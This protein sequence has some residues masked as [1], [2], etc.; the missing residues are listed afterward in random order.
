M[1]LWNKRKKLPEI[2]HLQFYI[3]RSVKNQVYTYLKRNM[4]GAVELDDSIESHLVEYRTP[5]NL[6]V[7]GELAQL[8]ER[9]VSDLPARCQV[10][11]RLVREDG[12]SYKE[13]AELLEISPKTV[14]NQMGI[15]IK[16]LKAVVEKYYGGGST[17]GK[18]FLQMLF[19]ASVLS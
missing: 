10:V 19:I 14:E 2:E 13:V 6:M 15:A 18:T 16:K 5:D 9:S 8:V 3:Y 11:F 12:L 1:K 17:G 7:T 4:K